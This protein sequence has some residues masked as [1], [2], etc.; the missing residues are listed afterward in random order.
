MASEFLFPYGQLN[1][2]SL[3]L[4]KREEIKKEIGLVEIEVVEIFEYGKNNNRY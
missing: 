3:F 1:L 2:F 4:E